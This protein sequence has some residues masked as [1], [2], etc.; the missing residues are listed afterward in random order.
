MTMLMVHDDLY[1]KTRLSAKVLLFVCLFRARR[2]TLSVQRRVRKRKLG[3][4]LN[5]VHLFT[6]E[7]LIVILR[8]DCFTKDATFTVAAIS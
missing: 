3:A 4:V 1:K 8:K 7:V 6:F 5:H 2:K